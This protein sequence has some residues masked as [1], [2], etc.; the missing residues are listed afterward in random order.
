MINKKCPCGSGKKFAACCANKKPRSHSVTIRPGTLVDSLHFNGETGE[1][2]LF[3]KGERVTPEHATTQ[4]SY[5]RDAKPPKILTKT[6][7][8]LTKIRASPNASL[9]GYDK[10]FSVDTNTKYIDDLGMNLSITGIVSGHIYESYLEDSI[11]VDYGIVGAI[12]F[13]GIKSS[14]ERI[15][16]KKTIQEIQSNKEFPLLSKIGLIVDSYID[17]IPSINQRTLPVF[18]DFYLPNKFHLMYANSDKGSESIL[19]KMIAAADKHAANIMD[20]VIKNRP[21]G[22][23]IKSSEGHYEYIRYW[24][25]KN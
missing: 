20:R 13:W 5:Q 21:T 3:Y 6:D 14:H 8:A 10:I 19:N 12:E 7:T 23:V 22:G 11:R 16:W 9:C 24:D 2:R 1:I 17:E 4:I 25:E 18:E 15:G